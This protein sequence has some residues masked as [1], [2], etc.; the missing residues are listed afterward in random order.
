M[1]IVLIFEDNYILINRFFM[2]KEERII[3]ILSYT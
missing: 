1:I 2:S 3:S